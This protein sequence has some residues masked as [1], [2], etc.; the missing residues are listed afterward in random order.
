MTM[1][2]GGLSATRVAQ[3]FEGLGARFSNDVDRDMSYFQLRSLADPERLNPALDMLA[4]VLAKPDFPEN[5]FKREK[6]RTL[7]GLKRQKQSPSSIAKKA[8]YQALYGDH[9]YGHLPSGTEEG[10]TAIRLSNVKAFHSKMFVANNAVIAIVGSISR[11]KAAEIAEKVVSGLKRNPKLKAVIPPVPDLKKSRTVRIHH[12]SSQ[13]HILLGHPAYNR[14]EPKHVAL[15]VG[16]HALGGS[17]LVSR[18]SEEVREKRGLA[19]SVYSYFFPLAE[20]GPFIM[21]MQTRNSQAEQG[22]K[23]MKDTLNRYLDKGMT[24]EELD[25]SK[26]NITGGFPLRIDSNKK[27][28]GYIA[29]IGF[30]QLPL[31]YLDDF[32]RKVENVSLSTVNRAMVSMVKP[33]RMVTVIVGGDR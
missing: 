7:L 22:L 20:R 26:K 31:T 9:P 6:Q 12:P 2:A 14:S 27:I 3:R 30:Y 5:D 15:Y 28:L 11:N 4:T 21:G 19:Y 8:F 25:A 24:A 33:D 29:M 32:N 16:N 18:L 10:V 23:V 17:G 13:T 1:G